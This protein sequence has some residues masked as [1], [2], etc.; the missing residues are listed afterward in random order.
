MATFFL[1]LL[2]NL[3]YLHWPALWLDIAYKLMADKIHSFTYKIHSNRQDMNKDE[4]FCE[5]IDYYWS[6]YFGVRIRLHTKN[7]PK[8]PWKA[9]VD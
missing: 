3:Q 5:R 6:L 1:Y 9:K 4:Y 8:V 2:H 7:E